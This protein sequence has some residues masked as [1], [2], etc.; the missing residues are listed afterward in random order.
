MSILRKIKD[1]KILFPHRLKEARERSGLTS[2]E[3]APLVNTTYVSISIWENGKAF[4]RDEFIY[5]L[6]EVLNVEVDWLLGFDKFCYCCGKSHEWSG[7]I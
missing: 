6:A 4:P 5:S 1:M 7:I 3:L 2:R